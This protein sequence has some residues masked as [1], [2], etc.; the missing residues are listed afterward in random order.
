MW[1][2]IVELKNADDVYVQKFCK[3]L[4]ITEALIYHET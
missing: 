3:M 2:G 1:G 4:L